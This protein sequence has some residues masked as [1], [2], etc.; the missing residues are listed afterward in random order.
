MPLFACSRCKKSFEES[1]SYNRKLCSLCRVQKKQYR[2][3]NLD[4]IRQQ[5]NDYRMLHRDNLNQY[6]RDYRKQNRNSINEFKRN[7]HQN[8]IQYKLGHNLRSRLRSALK[9][10]TKVGSAVKDLGCTIDELKLWLED[11]FQSGMTWDNYGTYWH[12]DHIIPL[13]SFDLTDLGQFKKACHWF[14]LQP[15]RAEDNLSKK[16]KV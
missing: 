11:Q 12:I 15:L 2:L 6:L 9:R 13:A 16:D 7:R 14:N 5:S 8:D 1:E 4:K 10:N 3:R